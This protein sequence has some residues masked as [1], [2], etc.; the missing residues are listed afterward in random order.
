MYNIATPQQNKQSNS[1]ENSSIK[2]LPPVSEY[3]NLC[4]IQLRE[5]KEWAVLGDVSFHSLWI[6]IQAEQAGSRKRFPSL[7]KT[8]STPAVWGQL[9]LRQVQWNFIYCFRY[10]TVLKPSFEKL[11]WSLQAIVILLAL[12][13]A[14][15]RSLGKTGWVATSWLQS[16]TKK[17]MLLLSSSSMENIKFNT[18]QW[19]T[20]LP[21]VVE[22]LFWEQEF[23][24]SI[25]TDM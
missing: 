25:I 19:D 17:S 5:F 11:D 13:A 1:L 15:S 14:C 21:P 4:T 6:H 8:G 7:N 24:G 9:H 22:M 23:I 12:Y 20:P 10:S 2:L 3:R 18:S 16:H